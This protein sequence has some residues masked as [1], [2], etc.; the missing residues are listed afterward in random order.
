MA[1][2]SAQRHQLRTDG[3]GAGRR[4]L[5]A[6]IASVKQHARAQR[7]RRREREAALNK[8]KRAPFL[9]AQKDRFFHPLAVRASTP[10]PGTHSAHPKVASF[11]AASQQRA[12]KFGASSR[13]PLEQT[14][15]HS[16][17]SESSACVDA[18]ARCIA[19]NTSVGCTLCTACL[20]RQVPL[21][22]SQQRQAQAATHRTSRPPC[23][24]AG[25][26][27]PGKSLTACWRLADSGTRRPSRYH[28][29]PGLCVC[30]GG[31]CCGTRT[32]S[33]RLEA[34]TAVVA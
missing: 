25:R 17:V 2:S 23:P 27:L 14:Q 4:R 28:A 7:R 20:V 5:K 31:V 29:P 9:T 30:R 21:Y 33:S 1:L 16:G 10:G 34:D 13:P 12:P 15:L 32:W 11:W 26:A 3:S 18:D 24:T 8:H 6:Q 22:H 19:V